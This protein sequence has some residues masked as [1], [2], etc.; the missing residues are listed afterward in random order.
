[1]RS[2]LTKFSIYHVTAPGQEKGAASLPLHTPY[3]SMD[4]LADM[5]GSVCQYYGVNHCVGLGVGMGANVLLRLATKR[6]KLIDGL[7][8]INSNSQT[9]GWMEWAYNKVNMKALKG[10]SQVPD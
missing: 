8:V 3:P 4:Q 9:S 1:M 7:I 6:Q 2:I 10:A 5:L